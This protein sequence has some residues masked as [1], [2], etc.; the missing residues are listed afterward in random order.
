MKNVSA[1]V[2]LA[3]LAASPGVAS[4]AS[5]ALWRDV[6]AKSVP[7]A[8]PRLIQPRHART[9][10]FDPAALAGALRG[11]PLE[12]AGA[13]VL[14]SLPMPDGTTATFRVVESPV[15]Q[16]GLAAKY[17]RIRT[18]AGRSTADARVTG[19]FD[20]GP[21]GFHGMIFTPQGTAYIDP[22]SRGETRYHQAYYRADLPAR[23]R[24]PDQVLPR[25]A[26]LK[27][28]SAG[29]VPALGAERSIAGDLRTYRLALAANGEYSMFHDPQTLP[30][31]PRKEI[32]LAELVNVV[33]RVTGVYERELGIKLVLIDNN[34]LLIFQNSEADP[35]KND[36]PT[37]MVASNTGVI[38]GIVGPTAYDIGHVATTGGGGV[39]FLGVVCFEAQ[40]GGGVTGLPAPIGDAYYIDYVAHEMGHQFGGNHTF[41][42]TEGSC[43]GN[44]AGPAYEPGSGVTI[45]AY[46]GICGSQNIATHSIDTFHAASFDEIVAYTRDDTGNDCP[47]VTQSGNAPPVVTAPSGSFTVPK[48]TPFEFAGSATDPDGDALTY[49][50]EQMDLGPGGHPNDAA[51]AGGTPPLFRPFLPAT[52]GHRMFPQLGDLLA[53]KQTI[54]EILPATTREMNFRLTV[55]DNHVAPS[56][57]GVASATYKVNTT[58]AAGPFRVMDPHA[59]SV[60]TPNDQISVRWLVAGTTAAPVSCS[61]VDILL[62]NDNGE[63]FPDLLADDTPNDG[64]HTVT[65]PESVGDDTV[66]KVKC[67]NNIF[68]ALSTEN[69]LNGLQPPELSVDA[70]YEDPDTDGAYTLKWT[71]PATGV[72]PDTV[73]ESASCGPVFADDAAET[74]VAGANS[75]WSGSAQWTSQANPSDGS[76]AYYI[77]DGSS[78][79]EALSMID[80]IAIPEGA[81]ATLT[82]TTSQDTEE[83]YDFGRVRVNVDE[84]GFKTIKA[85]SGAYE[86]T[87]TVDLSQFAGHSIRIE[88]LMLSDEVTFGAPTG[89]YVDNIAITAT[90]FQDLATVAGTSLAIAGKPIG[91]YCYRARTTHLIE[92]QSGPS[93]HGNVVYV[94]V[95]STNLAP[96]ANAGADLAADEGTAVLLAGSGSDPEAGALT[97]QWTQVGG[98][99]VTLSNADAASA[100]FTAPAVD[101]DTPLTFRL[102]VTDAGDLS[103]S[104]DVVVTVRNL[105]AQQPTPFSFAERTGVATNVYVTSETRSITGFSGTLPISIDNGGQYRI[106]GGAWTATAGTIGSGSTLAVRHVSASTEGTTKA[107]KVTVGTY[108]TEFKTTTSSADRTPDAFNFTTQNGVEL[109]SEV[110]SN[111]VTPAGFNTAI[112]VVPGTGS[113]VSIDGGS[114]TN[115]STTMSPGQSIQTRHVSS[116]SSLSYTKTSV[117]VGTITAYFTT[118]TR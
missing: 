90:V 82:F 117:K 2:V 30:N 10:A 3:L 118:R 62:S 16:P 69:F 46:A 64:E 28:D 6:A 63:T 99:S 73:Q 4:A 79:A 59:Q 78:Q 58:A 31:L 13:G 92:G 61:A 71:R 114:W 116:S 25:S 43:G 7:L 32:V 22:Y 29:A 81:V 52:T 21:R 14:L 74:L 54:G 44:E 77:P 72:G 39:A 66:L 49:Q 103:G 48:Q 24:A 97:Y 70:D 1:A 101:A 51:T 110:V 17:P 23:G 85:W 47:V 106:N 109:S 57:G 60:Y 15:M 18:Y 5:T 53:D 100:N 12:G 112:T 95:A 76:T 41:N 113:W 87:R 38:S 102:T 55:R 20:L 83:D 86:G 37:S 91:D 98:P 27:R 26:P 104:D 19:R 56:A 89:W 88:F 84:T 11:A 42:G 50:W 35:Y 75:R 80:P 34:D 40:K 68:F 67:S 45:M 65:L 108:W 94:S 115:A 33:N 105:V 36:D 107:S 111:T 93:P 8:G 9:F 96:L